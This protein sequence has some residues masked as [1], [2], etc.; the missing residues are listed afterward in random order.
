MLKYYITLLAILFTINSNAQINFDQGYFINNKNEQID[1]W[2]KNIDWKNNPTKFHYK[3]SENSE[4][5]TATIET[6]KEFGINNYSKY[7]RFDINIDRSSKE[8]E[9]MSQSREP[10]FKKEQL[11][12]KI[13]VE[14]KAT[15]FYYQEINL[16]RY[17]IKTVDSEI[18]QL[19]FK[20]YKTPEN[21]V[22]ANK[23]FLIQLRDQLKCESTTFEKLRRLEYRKKSLVKLFDE[24]NQCA[25]VQYINFEQ[26]QKKDLFNLS[27]K[28]GIQISSLNMRL[29]S[30]NLEFDNQVGFKIGV[31]L[32]LILPF[33]KNKWIIFT[34]PSFQQSKNTTEVKSVVIGSQTNKV[35][36]EYK[37]VELPLG[38]KYY[39]FLNSN[40]KIFISGAYV[41]DFRLSSKVFYESGFEYPYGTGQNLV[42]GLG[43]N[44]KNK[45]NIEVRHGLSR[46]LIA[47]YK[48]SNADFKTVS[49]IFGY[50]IF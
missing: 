6:I 35:T 19:V 49:L 50:T 22:K 32:G 4:S 39:L 1:C 40:S 36:S 38:L 13:L 17:F 3:L 45:Y 42:F 25:K 12:L 46:N 7:Q 2:I 21:Q 16:K 43:Y 24:Y 23:Q 31:E 26:L 14:G 20:K 18:E 5:I 33:N 44:Y 9:S 37:S 15:L 8:L 10:E 28:S 34:E 48:G 29:G 47:T 41:L 27:L 30:R 11:F